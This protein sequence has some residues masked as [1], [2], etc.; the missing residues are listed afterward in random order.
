MN[1]GIP[2][3]HH[4]ACPGQDAFSYPPCPCQEGGL[5]EK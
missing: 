1:S 2:K 4:P 3:E 5:V